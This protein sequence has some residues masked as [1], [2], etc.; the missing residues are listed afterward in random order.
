MLNS[1]MSGVQKKAGRSPRHDPLDPNEEYYSGI[2]QVKSEKPHVSAE[3][4]KDFRGGVEGDSMEE[5]N[6]FRR[7]TT[8]GD[9]PGRPERRSVSC[10]NSLKI[11]VVFYVFFYLL[12]KDI[13]LL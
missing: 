13:C 10:I 1:W 11:H 8:T 12:K 7:V 6:D 2:A 4:D 3:E 9:S 5:D